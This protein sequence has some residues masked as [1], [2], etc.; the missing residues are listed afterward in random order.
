M[1][2]FRQAAELVSADFIPHSG[3]Q[4]GSA[5]APAISIVNVGS[6]GN[7]T[8]VLA[9]FT[10]SATAASVDQYAM[11]AFT[12]VGTPAIA[13][14]EAIAASYASGTGALALVTHN[15]NVAYKLT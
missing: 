8:T 2:N 4:A 12:M 15:L 11:G 6:D 9:S 5:D 10:P 14:G 13:A 3:S 7:G 1:V